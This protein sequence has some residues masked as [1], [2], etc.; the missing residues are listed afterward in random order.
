ML[1]QLAVTMYPP[2]FVEQVPLTQMAVHP[3]ASPGT[4]DNPASPGRTRK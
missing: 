4:P 3:V 1:M 2:E